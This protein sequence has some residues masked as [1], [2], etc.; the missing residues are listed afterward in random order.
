MALIRVSTDSFILLLV[1]EHI[2]SDKEIVLFGDANYLLK[3][4]CHSESIQKMQI[5]LLLSGL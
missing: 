2:K 5:C 1:C 4:T 3:F